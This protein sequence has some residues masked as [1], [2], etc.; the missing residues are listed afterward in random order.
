MKAASR[1]STG[2]ARCL[3]VILAG[4]LLTPVRAAAAD[5]L[6]ELLA[7]TGDQV[8]SFLDL[9]SDMNCTEHVTQLKLGDSGKTVEKQESAFDYL[10]LLSNTG[11]ELNL[12]ESRLAS[13]PK[14]KPKEGA[15]LLLSN[16]FSTL[17]LIFHPYYAAGFEFSL[18][19]QEM[20]DGRA[21]AKVHFEHIRGTRS[22]AALA[23]RG[24]EY[25]L[26][27]A[28]TA[29]IDPETGIIAKLE[30]ELESGMDDVG[31]RSLHTQVQYSPVSF[32]DPSKVYWLP[33]QATVEVESSH[34]HWRNIHTFS[35][36][37][38]FSVNTKEQI[39]KP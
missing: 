24:R 22:P 39:A 7:R 36:Y 34:Q 12:V 5:P 31:L 25:P 32:D 33:A 18:D 13:D 2:L 1:S 16:G 38:R 20:I 21:F 17:F 9:I 11:G 3:A 14:A 4:A 29:W 30:A 8:T 37:K 19:G 23:V 26:D 27:L 10:I 15:P 35:G 28:G 6:Q